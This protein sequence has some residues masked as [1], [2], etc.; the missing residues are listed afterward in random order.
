MMASTN[1][2]G[3]LHLPYPPS[4]TTWRRTVKAAFDRA[5]SLTACSKY[6]QGS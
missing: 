4:R 5:S 1:Q 6:H 3:S 2:R